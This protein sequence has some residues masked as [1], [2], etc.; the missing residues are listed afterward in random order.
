M[1][2]KNGNTK[3]IIAIGMLIVSSLTAYAQAVDDTWKKVVEK[4][5]EFYKFSVPASW[6]E[7]EM[8]AGENPEQYFEAS[9]K[10]LPETYNRAPVI[11][12]IFIVK[13]AADNLEEAKEKT[14]KGYKENPERVFAEGFSHEEKIV[15]LKSGEKAYVVNTRFY[16]K[17]KGL[18][19]SRYD[20][21]VYSPRAKCAY[22]YTLSVQYYD[23]EYK[24]EQTHKLQEV[25]KQLYE[26]F[27]L[28]GAA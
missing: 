8:R 22:L 16:R 7:M 23:T 3:T 4:E 24:F 13:M 11:V 18:H 26:R 25:A 14:V 20:L 17:G 27:Q 28:K 19:Q 9:G 6:Q 21:V 1:N 2:M 5:T 15:S 10:S 12:T